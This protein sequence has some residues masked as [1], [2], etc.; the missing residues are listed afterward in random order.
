MNDVLSLMQIDGTPEQWRKIIKASAKNPSERRKWYT[1][2]L[3]SRAWRL[4]REEVITAQAGMCGLCAVGVI[5]EVH[6]INYESLGNEAAGCLVGLCGTC[7]KGS[8]GR[9]AWSEFERAFYIT[10]KKGAVCNGN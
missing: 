1:A 10:P 8:H 4:R 5:E 3:N 6:H 2:Y 9:L 7:H